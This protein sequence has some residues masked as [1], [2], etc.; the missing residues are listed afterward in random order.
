MKI[1]V[2]QE[3]ID[4]YKPSSNAENCPVARAIRRATG[5]YASVH[6]VN[7]H[8]GKFVAIRVANTFYA[9]YARPYIKADE[10]VTQFVRRWD[11]GKKVEPFRFELDV[12]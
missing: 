6:N 11:E 5:K 8:S 9:A 2:T 12:N 4:F 3:D 7:N 1:S 10:I